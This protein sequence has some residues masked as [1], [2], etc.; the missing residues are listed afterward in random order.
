MNKHVAL[1]EFRCGDDVATFASAVDYLR[2]IR[3]RPLLFQED[4]I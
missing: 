4:S 3:V 1:E 2:K